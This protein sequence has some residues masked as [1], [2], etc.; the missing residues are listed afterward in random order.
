MMCRE[1]ISKRGGTVV[2]VYKDAA[3]FGWSLD[4]EDFSRL[5]SDAEQ[6]RFD[7]I[8]MWK[9]D[10]LARDHTQVT[11]IKALLRH[12]YKVKLYC[13]EGF[14]EDDDSSP[15]TA[16]MEQMLAVFAAFYSKNSQHRNQ[17]SKPPPSR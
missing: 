1:E 12:E 15:Y 11:I 7:A 3:Q 5:R 2:S 17:P 16:M 14:S 4:R 8:M 6:G 13:V 9:F 10:R